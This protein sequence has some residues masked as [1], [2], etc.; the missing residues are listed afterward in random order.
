MSLSGAAVIFSLPFQVHMKE[1]E[2][3]PRSPQ[4]FL[5]HPRN[6][7]NRN[8]FEMGDFIWHYFL[9]PLSAGFRFG[10]KGRV[11]PLLS[12]YCRLSLVSFRQIDQEEDRV[13]VPCSCLLWPNVSGGQSDSSMFLSMLWPKSRSL[14]LFWMKLIGICLSAYCYLTK[15]PLVIYLLN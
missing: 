2:N 12:R 4:C 13:L 7:D 8:C 1:K 11:S 6:F 3:T 15:L 14:F 9:P 5:K 10:S